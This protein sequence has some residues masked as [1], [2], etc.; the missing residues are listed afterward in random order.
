MS[1]HT[2]PDKLLAAVLDASIACMGA[3]A[4]PRVF[5]RRAI[6]RMADI[7]DNNAMPLFGALLSRP[8]R[9]RHRR[10]RRAAMDGRLRAGAP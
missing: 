8:G 9:V 4:D 7:W 10:G 3:A 5:D 1:R 6:V 2:P